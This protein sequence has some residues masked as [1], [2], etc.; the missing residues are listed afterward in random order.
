MDKILKELKGHSGSQIYLME[1][2]QRMFVRKIDNVQRNIERLSDLYG[3]GYPVPKI[4]NYS[5][6]IID[7]EYIHGL[8]MK[9]YLTH[10]NIDSLVFFLFDLID[11]FSRNTTSKDY[12]KIYFDKLKWMDE[13]NIFPFTKEQLIEKLPKI[14]PKSTYHGDLTLENIMYTKSGFQLIDA[15]TIE[16]DSF[17]FDIAKM[18]QDLECKWFLRDSNIK[19]DVKLK[20]IQ[21]KLKQK[22]PEAFNDSLLILMLLRVFL[23]TKKDDK[24]YH[25]IMKEVKRLWK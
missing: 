9:N 24:N 5:D 18:R 15:V 20:N 19:L 17:I 2:D 13:Y 11:R 12:T 8:D 4:Y 3:L 25:F 6:N 16:Y 7:M 10:S 14:L 21:R 22:Y 23:H 1:N